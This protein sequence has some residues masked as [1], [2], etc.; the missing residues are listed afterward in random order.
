MK[1]IVLAAMLTSGLMASDSGMY[2]GIDAGQVKTSESW[3]SS[4]FYG[5]P[6]NLTTT[7]SGTFTTTGNAATVK[8]GYYLNKNSRAVMSIQRAE[9]DGGA[10]TAVSVGYDYL[11]GDNAFKPFIGVLAGYASFKPD[12]GESVNGGLFGGQAGINYAINENFSLEAGYRYMKS[13]ADYSYTTKPTTITYTDSGKIDTI[14]SW[15]IGA[16]YKF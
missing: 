14:T 2:V 11:I 3:T 12:T 8:L 15:F 7:N 13:N 9:F 4:A 5:A 1:K 6:S 16:N 10:E